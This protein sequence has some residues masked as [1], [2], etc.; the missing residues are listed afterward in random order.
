MGYD[1][2]TGQFDAKAGIMYFDIIT[3]DYNIEEDAG[4]AAEGDEEAI[5]RLVSSGLGVPPDS[6]KACDLEIAAIKDVEKLLGRSISNEG[7]DV[8]GSLIC[9]FG[10]DSWAE[11]KR[12]NDIIRKSFG[13]GDDEIYLDTPYTAA[14]GFHLYPDEGFTN[15]RCWGVASF[16]PEGDLDEWLEAFKPIGT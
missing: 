10:V 15:G 14:R 4:N 12:I 9:K 11:V 13:G 7:H 2:K 5:E 8:C 6:E 16:R 3:E 1:Q